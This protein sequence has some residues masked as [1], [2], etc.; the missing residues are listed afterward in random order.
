M[1]TK[2]IMKQSLNL[3]VAVL[4]LLKS[5]S[6]SSRTTGN[7]TRG[8]PYSVLTLIALRIFPDNLLQRCFGSLN[9][10]GVLHS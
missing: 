9:E 6:F 7:S 8:Q 4:S 5:I 3:L 1:C 10:Y 2:G